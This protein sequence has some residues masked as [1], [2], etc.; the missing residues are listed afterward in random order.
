MRWLSKLIFI[1]FIIVLALPAFSQDLKPADDEE[2]NLFLLSLAS[3]FICAMIGA[4]IIGAIA[5]S[6]FLFFVFALIALGVLS[7]SIA[8][9]LYKRSFSAGF[10][11][12]MMILFG[13]CC[14][15]IGGVGLLIVDHLAGLQP[16][17]MTSFL[18]GTAAGLIG[19]L[20][21]AIATIRMFQWIAKII[22]RK[23]RI[24]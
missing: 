1:F 22:A 5:A 17:H 18:V 15:I 12:F 14:S 6:L 9:G 7:T 20:L 3:I 19:G 24:A 8:L 21:M 23:F 10:Q 11:T 2:F 16:S 13:V 4:A